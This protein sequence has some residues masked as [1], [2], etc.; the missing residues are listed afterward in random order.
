MRK[1]REK[2][3]EIIQIKILSAYSENFQYENF[4]HFMDRSCHVNYDGKMYEGYL[5]G[6]SADKLSDQLLV[7]I[8]DICSGSDG[9]E[10]KLTSGEPFRGM[11]TNHV[12]C[13]LANDPMDLLKTNNTIYLV[14]DYRSL[15]R[16]EYLTVDKCTHSAMIKKFRES[17][18]RDE[19]DRVRDGLFNLFCNKVVKF[20]TQHAIRQLD[21]E[22]E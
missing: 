13:S 15:R 19:I 12:W 21:L 20:A 6:Y 22:D 1:R 10:H 2:D 4:R 14:G 5:V 16:Y 9:T 8:E 7:Y 17:E 18:S 3:P 11:D